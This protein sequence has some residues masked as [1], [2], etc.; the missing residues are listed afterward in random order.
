VLGGAEDDGPG[1]LGQDHLGHAVG[2]VHRLD[3]GADHHELVAA[4]AGDG[5]GAPARFGQT[6][7]QLPQGQVADGVAVQVVDGLEAVEVDEEDGQGAVV[8][9]TDGQGLVDPVV[10]QGPVGEAGEGVVEGL[11]L[12][13]A[14]QAGGQVAVLGHQGTVGQAPADGP[15][16]G[17]GGHGFEEVAVDLADGGDGT[18]ERRRAG[19]EQDREGGVPFLQGLGQVEPVAVGEEV[20][21]HHQGGP[22]VG[23]EGQGLLG[24]GRPDGGDPRPGQDGQEAGPGGDVVVHHQDGV[25][26]DPALGGPSPEGGRAGR[27]RRHGDRRRARV[28]TVDRRSVRPAAASACIPAPRLAALAATHRRFSFYHSTREVNWPN[29]H[30]M[31]LFVRI[32]P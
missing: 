7:G 32:P 24:A 28:I 6:V 9:A 23:M 16:E 18:L 25:G 17:V 26:G 27:R 19:E 4:E 10:E 11:V 31:P 22:G 20:V 15:D 21:D 29:V 8:A 1:E 13:E 2:D 3:V 14:F 30:S 12:A 5:V